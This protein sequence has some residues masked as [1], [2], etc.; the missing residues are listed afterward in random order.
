VEHMILSTYTIG[1]PRRFRNTQ[2]MAGPLSNVHMITNA[3]AGILVTWQ[4][5]SGIPGMAIT[6]GTSATVLNTGPVVPGQY[7]SINPVLQAQDGSYIGTADTDE[8]SSLVRFNASGNVSWSL[9]GLYTPK[10]AAAD[11]GFIA[12]TWD[13][14]AAGLDGTCRNVRSERRRYGADEPA[15]VFMVGER[16]PGW[17]CRASGEKVV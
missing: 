13:A 4:T 14:D 9:R 7:R 3:D 5:D 2:P 1:R 16:I 11:G 17:V 12:Q 8:G 6:T 10:I 15:H